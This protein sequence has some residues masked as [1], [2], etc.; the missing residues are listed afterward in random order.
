MSGNRVLVVEDEELIRLILAEVLADEGFHVVEAGTGDEAAALL[1]GPD[2]F[3]AVVTDI[4]MPGGRDGLAV[5]RHARSRHPDI[6][7]VYCTGRPDVLNDAGPL[8][9]RDALV[10]KPYVPS[11]IVMV[12]QRLLPS[13]DGAG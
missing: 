6:P 10:R 12:L 13:P 5:G 1:D 9:R 8:G 7:V 11:Q 2:G 4:H 3:H